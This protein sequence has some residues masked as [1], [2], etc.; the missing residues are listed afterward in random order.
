MEN[1][2][3]WAANQLKLQRAIA[4]AG[5]DEAE[6]KKYY[7]SIGGLV[8]GEPVVAPK[9]DVIPE[10]K[11]DIKVEELIEEEIKPEPKKRNVRKASK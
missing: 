3:T 6:V 10:F 9:E 2:Y 4:M 11:E 7:I 5:P 8:V 1:N